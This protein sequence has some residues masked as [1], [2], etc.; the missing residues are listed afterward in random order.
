MSPSQTAEL[1]AAE[2]KQAVAFAKRVGALPDRDTCEYRER[3]RTWAREQLAAAAKGE[4]LCCDSSAFA[5]WL[6]KIADALEHGDLP[7]FMDWRKHVPEF[8]CP[9]CGIDCGVEVNDRIV[10]GDESDGEIATATC[11]T[12]ER[13]WESESDGADWRAL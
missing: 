7:S 1:I 8:K 10:N 11:P 2:N 4:A 5:R 3:V 12:C 9:S 6:S 13:H